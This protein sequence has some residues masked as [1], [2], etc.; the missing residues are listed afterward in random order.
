LKNNKS[1]NCRSKVLFNVSALIF[2]QDFQY[3]KIFNIFDQSREILGIGA[4]GAM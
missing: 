3:G 1:K 4:A 2:I